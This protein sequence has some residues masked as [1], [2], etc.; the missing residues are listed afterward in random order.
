MTIK[1]GDYVQWTWNSPGAVGNVIYKVEE[2]ADPLSTTPSGF[3]SGSPSSL[4]INLD[5]VY[6]IN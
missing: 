3:S 5:F 1:K 6:C 2:V 4:G